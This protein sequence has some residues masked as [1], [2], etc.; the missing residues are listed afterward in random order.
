MADT[1][2]GVGIVV[3]SHS[4]ALATAA[5]ALASEMLHGQDARIELAAGL[6]ETTFGTDAVR[7]KEA[8]EALDGP[9]GVVVLM[10][11]G[12]AVLSAELALDLLDDPAARDR[13]TLSAAP[14]VEG[15]V[16]AAVAAAGGASREEVAAE[17][18]DA[19]LAKA[20]HLTGPEDAPVEA[21]TSAA[22]P[23]GAGVD[24]TGT[25][26]VT[27]PHGLHARPAARL[28]GEVRGLDATLTLTNLTTGAGPVPAGS[29]SRV[30]MLA[31]QQGHEVEVRASG[32]GADDAVARVLALADRRFDEVE[33]VV[34]SEPQ[35][36]V[37]AGS[38][39]A[40]P[41]IAI[42]PLR[43]FGSAVP[44]ADDTP[45]GTPDAEWRRVVEAV[46]AVRRE[47]AQVRDTTRREVGAAEAGIF[48]A[49]LGLLD[50][51]ALLADAEARVGAGAGAFAAWS[52]SVDA[53]E[54][55]W[56]GL[57]DVY[58]RERAADV[59]AVGD[60]VR[61]A[62]VPVP[63]AVPAVGEGVLVARDLT[64]AQVAVLE[65]GVV[66]AI[67]LAAGS[68]TSHAAILARSRDIPLVVGA[69]D[70]VLGVAESTALVVDGGAGTV[71]V[72]PA[73]DVV[74]DYRRRAAALA[75]RRAR[76]LAA[77][78]RPAATLDGTGVVVAA[79]L[80]SVDD[81]VAAAAAG[82]DESGLV[83]TEFLFLGRDAAPDV[84]EQEAEYAAIAAAMGGRRITLRTLD[85]G[86][87]KPLA[88]VPMPAEDNPFLGVRGLRLALERPALLRDQLEAVVRTARR[89]PVSL[90]FPMVST[91]SELRA[92]R[93]VLAQVA[94]DDPV[95]ALRVGMMVEVPAAA[96]KLET[97]LPLLDFVSI[98]SNDLT[99]YA[100][101][102]ERGNP[103]V[104]ALSDP[105]D[106]SVLRLVDHVCRAADGR[107]DVAVCGEMAA[108]D[109][110]VPVL[111]GLGVRELS[112]A[113]AAVPRVKA[114]VRGLD[115]ATCRA[116]AARALDLED[117]A[118]VR[119]LVLAMVPAPAAG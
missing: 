20:A 114:R 82:A 7:V 26:T 117:A 22:T 108:D 44:D 55:E 3:V 58:L 81:A 4:R 105:L 109:A 12:S 64:P 21:A 52:A 71:I 27:N 112:V 14:V 42:G 98:G 51:E 24:A 1:A 102:A 95:D 46:A 31:A 6:D 16:V 107:I 97:F 33:D 30:A 70:H 25:F 48:E 72:D 23:A 74:A 85:V 100:L 69:G 40:S 39:G 80:G 32:P 77:G 54:S 34:A 93:E 96:L 49:H 28:V 94:G 37:S 115:L 15:L 59:R 11:L 36:S 29:L 116:V 18:R 119:A 9:A 56:A 88:Y 43:R 73:P 78:G 103:G 84:D 38:V 89:T 50:D 2:P 83:R 63:A 19:L 10:D 53:L 67:V 90:M 99:Q 62:L 87:D 79:N 91:A 47:V 45:V 60:Q 66:L 8:I 17:A 118:A 13:V 111:L 68:T 110:A 104:A 5:Q 113:P 57:P 65:A 41:G 35:P 86:G 61:R 101:A 92:A 76:D 106:P 75:E